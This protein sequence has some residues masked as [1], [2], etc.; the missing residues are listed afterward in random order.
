MC[1]GTYLQM[2]MLAGALANQKR[3]SG[4]L[5]LELQVVVSWPMKMLGSNLGTPEEKKALWTDKPSL[6][7]Q[8]QHTKFM[9]RK[10]IWAQA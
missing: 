1:V 9:L 2:D 8:T 5:E 10:H 6:Q 7:L 3:M 4:P